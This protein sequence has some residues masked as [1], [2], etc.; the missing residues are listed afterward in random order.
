MASP[1]AGDSTPSRSTENKGFTSVEDELI[2][3][4]T[5]IHSS[6][7]EP[8]PDYED[9]KQ[10]Y[11]D[12]GGYDTLDPPATRPYSSSR[13]KRR[14]RSPKENTNRKRKAKMPPSKKAKRKRKDSYSS[15][16][17]CSS[18]SPSSLSS[19]SSGDS[20]SEDNIWQMTK[21]GE[22]NSWK[23]PKDLA[24]SFSRNLREHYTEA[25]IRENILEDFPVP[26]NID[27][28][29]QLD[30]L[31][32][33][34]LGE[35]KNIYATKNDQSLARISNKIRDVTGP[36][37][38]VWRMCHAKKSSKLRA[39]AIRDKLDKS[40][41]LLSQAI[42]AVTFHRRRAV[43][44]SL[45]RNRERAH[46]WVKDKY[47]HQLQDGN[48]NLFGEKFF[49]QIQKDAKAVDL[50]TLPYLQCVKKPQQPFRQGS[51][52]YQ[53][54]ESGPVEQGRA[55]T[56]ANSRSS[57][58]KKLES[59][60]HSEQ[61]APNQQQLATNI[62]RKRA[63]P[64]KGTAIANKHKIPNGGKI[65]TLPTPMAKNNIR[66]ND[67]RLDNGI[68]N[69]SSGKTVS[70]VRTK[71]TKT[72]RNSKTS[73]FIRGAKHAGHGCNSLSKTRK[74]T[75]YKQH[76]SKRKKG[77]RSV[78]ANSQSEAIE[79]ICAI[80]KIQNGNFKKCPRA[81]STW[82][83][84]SKNRSQTCLLLCEP[85]IKEQETST[86]SM[87]R[88]PVRIPLPGIWPGT[89]PKGI[90]KNS[91]SAHD[92]SKEAQLQDNNLHRRYVDNGKISGRNR[93]GKRHH[94]V[95]PSKSRICNKLGKISTDTLQNHRVSGNQNKLQQYDICNSRKE[96]AVNS[97]T[98]SR[99]IRQPTNNPPE[100]SQNS[101]ETYVN[102][103]SFY[104]CSNSGQ[105]SAEFV[106]KESE[107]QIIRD[108]ST[109]VTRSTF[110]AKM[111]ER[112]HAPVQLSR[113]TCQNSTPGNDNYI[114]CSG[115]PSGGLGS[116]LPRDVH[117]GSMVSTGKEEAYKRIG[118]D[119]SRTGHQNIHQREECELHTFKGGQHHGPFIYNENGGHQKPSTHTNC[120]ENMGLSS[121]EKDHPDCRIHPNKPKQGGRLSI[122]EHV[123]FQRMETEPHSFSQDMPNIGEATNRSFCITTVTSTSPVY[124]Q[125]IR[126]SQR[127][128]ECL[129]TKLEPHVPICIPP[130]LQFNRANPEESNETWNRYVTHCP[131][132]GSTTMVPPAPGNGYKKP[133]PIA[134][135]AQ[136]LDKSRGYNTPT[137]KK[138]DPEN[139]G[140]AHLREQLQSTGISKSASNLILNARTAGTRNNYNTNWEKFSCWCGEQQVDPFKCP[141]RYIINFLAYLYD[142][143]KAYRTI[144]NYRSAIS[145]MHCPIE[146][147]KVGEHP[148]VRRL[149]KGISK[150]RPPLPK[151][152][153]IWDVDQVLNYIKVSLPDNNTLTSM[154]LSQKAITLLGLTAIS[155]GSELHDF[156]I[157]NTCKINDSYQICHSRNAKHSKQGKTNPPVIFCAFPQDKALCPVTAID[158]YISMT[159][160]WRGELSGE[161][162]DHFGSV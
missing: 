83:L 51:T 91:K 118:N 126:T 154:Q 160:S 15:S 54:T 97:P 134:T 75:N 109:P 29:P 11:A 149:L 102:C 143:N 146:G 77:E 161:D 107:Q 20:S 132:M 100:I 81:P 44:T 31:M 57:R 123:G 131:I 65:K 159:K 105:I 17:S 58:G 142:N 74:G 139:N 151:Y 62:S 40:M 37:S 41:T 34:Y 117:R 60:S 95:S 128:K 72:K 71:T 115:G 114:R 96:N 79:P 162:Q 144:N 36:L 121:V 145:A 87:E 90:Y 23:L 25:E 32:E 18:S 152:S 48:G 10:D 140:M 119:S 12:S 92:T 153:F 21:S 1:E 78:Q 13:K 19:E 80:R 33:T 106:A 129:T 112:E 22:E 141:L 88:K 59:Q 138:Q 67:T 130:P 120:K 68:R 16:S 63:P 135:T 125:T 64:N 76:I 46:R 6:E 86:F 8:D 99:D 45:A 89:G 35:T 157:S 101:G 61:N 85:G 14:L 110:G 122:P 124:E 24:K 9:G 70:N 47:K 158:S 42:S 94:S 38:Q 5:T 147:F 69:T 137:S 136:P 7:R 30:S 26:K 98:L 27:S 133:D 156:K 108:Q 73:S 111:V 2:T 116:S 53:R 50:N 113:E 43:L 3:K 155:R 52:A 56:T 82:R 55:T 66:S 93:D 4:E 84:S 148:Q 49:K 103:S 28:T 104:A 127:G 150:E 39:T